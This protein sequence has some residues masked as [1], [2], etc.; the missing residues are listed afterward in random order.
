MRRF[1]TE[2]GTPQNVSVTVMSDNAKEFCKGV[3]PDVLLEKG[4]GEEFSALVTLEQNR[5][6]ERMLRTIKEMT[7]WLLVQLGLQA[8]FWGY[9]VQLPSMIWNYAPMSSNNEHRPPNKL[10]GQEPT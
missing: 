2:V 5:V 7:R 6:A 8:R 4:I 10:L 9:A 1:F 3:L